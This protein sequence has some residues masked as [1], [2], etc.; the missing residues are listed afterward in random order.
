MSATKVKKE[1]ETKV[2]DT[3]TEDESGNESDDKTDLK[4][5]EKEAKAHFRSMLTMLPTPQKKVIKPYVKNLTDESRD[6]RKR[7]AQLERD[8]KRK[9]AELEKLTAANE[10][11][12]TKVADL[13][14]VVKRHEECH[15]VLKETVNSAIKVGSP[16]TPSGKKITKNG[17]TS[18]P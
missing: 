15:K 1:K 14:D 4:Q 13:K 16:K 3:T 18:T 11:L 8:T 7:L 9:D 10:K 6:L 5:A 2:V 17:S 12:K